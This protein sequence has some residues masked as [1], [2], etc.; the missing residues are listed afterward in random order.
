MGEGQEVHGRKGWR[1][2]KGS[3]LEKG[4]G[5]CSTGFWE[6]KREAK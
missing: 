6:G 4:P 5:A 1:G 2:V 3:T